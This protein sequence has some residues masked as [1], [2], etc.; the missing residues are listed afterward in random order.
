MFEIDQ[1]LVKVRA[2]TNVPEFK[3][4]RREHACSV[5]FEFTTDNTV[6]DEFEPG[7]RKAFYE[8]DNGKTKTG[9]DGQQELSLP[10]QD[11]DL[12]ARKLI[13]I[14]MP[15]KVKKEFAGYELVYHCGATEESFI[16]LGEVGLSDFSFDLQQGG[17]VLVVFNAYSKPSADV[18]GRIDHM[19]QTEIEITLRAPT[20]KQEDLVEKASKSRKK[21]AAE[22][23]G[24][25]DDPFA[26]S[27]LAQDHTR[28]DGEQSARDGSHWPF[29]ASVGTE[30]QPDGEDEV[31][32]PED[33]GTAWPSED[34]DPVPEEDEE[35]S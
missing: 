4:E 31:H 15:L 18:Q 19:A 1:K 6:L 29:P 12:T 28:I 34:G 20:A 24:G 2:V 22:K 21:T 30:Q 32:P 26:H 25:S 33:A 9:D 7:L 17:S 8:K 16:K 11:L 5:K 35:Q 14:H 10:R 13:G 3:G 27:D 23:V